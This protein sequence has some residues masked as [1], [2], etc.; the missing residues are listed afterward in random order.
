MANVNFDIKQIYNKVKWAL[1]FPLALQGNVLDYSFLTRRQRNLSPEFSSLADDRGKPVFADITLDGIGF[2]LPP[3]V[4]VSGSL[5]VVSTAVA[6]RDGTV[7][8]IV[9]VEDYRVNIKCFLTDSI[10]D[11]IENQ[12]GFSG[13]K[14]RNDEFPEQR[15]RE[16]RNLF[17]NKRSV[18]VISP[19]LNIFNIQY[20]L[21]TNI[22]FPDLDGIT[23]IVPCE[24]QCISDKPLEIR[25]EE[26]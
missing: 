20:L 15:V 5:N 18:R 25:L 7:K 24:L 26:V 22:S 2:S 16:I 11:S 10:F 6:G 9:S 17:E 4:T 12:E 8:E 14:L 23:S 1:P 3:I 21:I 19:Y 13:I